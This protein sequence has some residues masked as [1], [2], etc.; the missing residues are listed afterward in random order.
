VADFTIQMLRVAWRVVHTVAFM[1]VVPGTVLVLIPS[2]VVTRRASYSL[3]ISW[4]AVPGWLTIALGSVIV[5][6]CAIGF[7]V[8]GQGTVAFYDPPRRLVTG[9]LYRWVRNP[10]YL[11]ATVILLGESI[12]FRSVELVAYAGMFWLVF[13]LWVLFVEEPILNAKF[14]ARYEQ[15]AGEVPRWLP[16]FRR[17]R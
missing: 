12:V 2:Q 14:G 5:L 1:V 15:C 7:I 11:G 17:Y 3:V 6:V 9:Q 4:L 10:L 8:E 16:S 13:H